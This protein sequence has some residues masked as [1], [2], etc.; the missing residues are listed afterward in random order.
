MLMNRFRS[1]TRSV[2][3]RL[4]DGFAEVA[5]FG[6][7]VT[8]RGGAKSS[9]CGVAVPVGGSRTTRRTPYDWEKQGDFPQFATD[10]STP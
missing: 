1:F 8:T 2:I 3:T 10:E 4:L 9:G 5:S 6:A 7:S